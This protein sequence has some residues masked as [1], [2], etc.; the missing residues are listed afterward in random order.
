MHLYIKIVVLIYIQNG[1]TA[2][3]KATSIGKTEIVKLLI[4]AGVDLNLQTKVSLW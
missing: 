3:Y 2:L 4:D 1:E